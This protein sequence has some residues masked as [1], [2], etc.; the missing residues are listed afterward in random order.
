MSTKTIL[1]DE[2]FRLYLNEGWD[3]VIPFQSSVEPDFLEQLELRGLHV[4]TDEDIPD[5]ID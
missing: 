4:I 3:E 2:A 5:E 1:Y